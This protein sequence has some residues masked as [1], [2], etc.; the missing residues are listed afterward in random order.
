[1]SHCA[2]IPV[3]R[4]ALRLSAAVL[5]GA[6]LLMVPLSAN[7]GSTGSTALYTPQGEGAGTPNGDY[8][9]AIAP[10]LDTVYSYFIEVPPSLSR[11]AVEIFDADIGAGTTT[12]AT[13]GRDRQRETTAGN[14]WNTTAT[15]SLVS[16]SGATRN[17]QFTTGNS[18][19]PTGAD[20]AWLALFDSTGDTVRDNFTTA[21]YTNNDGT[22][23]WAGNWIETN[24]DGN[25]GAGNIRIT[26]G[27]LRIENNGSVIE[28][29]ANLSGSGF[30]TATF[31]FNFRMTGVD[32]G[33]VLQV[34]VSAN[35]GG[36][37][38]NLETFTGLVAAA[39]RSYTITT[40]IAT[41]TRIRF[42]AGSGYGNNDFFFVDNLQIQET[43][44]DA[45]HWELRVDMSGAAA[46][47]DDINAIGIRAHDGTSDSG[48][49]ELNVYY[50]SQ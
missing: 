47:D 21:A 31:S 16:P 3:S 25:A 7:A 44:I 48:G 22:V 39:T 29:E 10:G 19:S 11:L 34:Q 43:G 20:N 6:V 17:T 5:F 27:E 23:N 18:T 4:S 33:D 12:E 1:M 28:R 24:D 35:G 15:Y 14:G 38:T 41:N 50:D 40:S 26:G 45:G 8:I 37:W 46:A 42:I 49:T 9:T 36:S 13:A 2:A 30:S 32:A